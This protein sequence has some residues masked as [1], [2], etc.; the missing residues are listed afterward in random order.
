MN[1]KCISFV[2]IVLTVQSISALYSYYAISNDIWDK[3]V[4]NVNF[5]QL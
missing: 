3:I 4:A 2:T 1:F 5:T